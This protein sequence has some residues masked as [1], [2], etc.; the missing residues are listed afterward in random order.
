MS[1]R[2]ER[3]QAMDQVVDV[4]RRL[5]ALADTATERRGLT[6]ARAAMLV[7]LH[8]E[9]SLTGVDLAKRLD[10]TPRNVTALVDA[11]EAQ[12]LVTRQPHPVDRRALL[13]ALTRAGRTIAAGMERGYERM[14]ETLL[15]GFSE[16]DLTD[17]ERVA[18]LLAGALDVYQP[19]SRHG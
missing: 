13:V 6:P 4:V 8:R 1:S 7:T 9:G 15:A 18:A 16:R 5:R 17:L 19:G 2:V 3:R 11:L 14:T 12:G 10:V